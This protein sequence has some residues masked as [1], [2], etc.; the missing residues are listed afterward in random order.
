MSS[1]KE[2]WCTATCLSVTLKPIRMASLKIVKS[3]YGIAQVGRRFQRSI[4]PWLR[5]QGFCQLD[6]SDFSVWVYNSDGHCG[7][8]I[9]NGPNY[10][11]TQPITEPYDAD[12]RMES[13]LAT[14]HASNK[15]EKLVLGV[16]VDNLQMVHSSRIDEKGSRVHAFMKAIEAEWDVK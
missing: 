13:A 11:V 1:S 5:S 15:H 7:T 6:D 2:K 9:D 14:Y 12:S 8:K 4:Y 16:Y 10:N 3:I